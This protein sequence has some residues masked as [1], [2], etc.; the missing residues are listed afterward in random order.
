MEAEALG[1]TAEAR[2]LF[3]QAW[4]QAADDADTFTAAH[5]LARNQADPAK[6]LKWNLE[7]LNRAASLDREE[8]KQYYPSLYLNAGKSYE[9][10]GEGEDARR[11]YLLAADYAAHLPA[12]KY[13]DM[14]RAGVGQGLERTGGRPQGDPLLETLVNAWCERRELKPLSLLLPAYLSHLGTEADLARL[15]SA[16]SY[17]SATRCLPPEEQQVIDTLIR[18]NTA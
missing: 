14:I 3:S 8:I 5:Y 12:G 16:L 4:E 6:A 18:E 9:D 10:L 1:K 7:A 13:S 17:L 11:H 2:E 15:T